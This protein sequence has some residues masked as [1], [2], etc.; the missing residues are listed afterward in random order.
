MLSQIS[1]SVTN[2]NATD[3]TRNGGQS[4]KGT[5][6]RYNTKKRREISRNG[7]G[8]GDGD[9]D[10]T[11]TDRRVRVVD[12]PVE[13]SKFGRDRTPE[14]S[15]V[16][17]TKHKHGFQEHPPGPGG[18]GNKR[19]EF[20]FFPRAQ[21]AGAT[22]GKARRPLLSFQTPLKEGVKGLPGTS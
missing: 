15:D 3:T 5:E 8:D 16:A 21:G 2:P 22:P 1:H 11:H 12:M 7:N 17:R 9:E 6:S 18:R 13:F 20:G 4:A 19:L 10:T 14:G